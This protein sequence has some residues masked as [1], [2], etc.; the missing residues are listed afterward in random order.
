MLVG[1]VV[2]IFGFCMF[3]LTETGAF[4]TEVAEIPVLRAQ[5]DKDVFE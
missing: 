1:M 4:E 3:F 2:A 5:A